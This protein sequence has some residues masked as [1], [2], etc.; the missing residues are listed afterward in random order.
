MPFAW[1][2]DRDLL[3]SMLAPGIQYLTPTACTHAFAKAVGGML[4]LF[5]RLICSLHTALSVQAPNSSSKEPRVIALYENLP[6]L[7]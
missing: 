4:A 7:D 1:R 2:L 5:P 3:A 6:Q